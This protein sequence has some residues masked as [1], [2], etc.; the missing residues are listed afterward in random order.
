[1]FCFSLFPGRLSWLSIYFELLDVGKI[2]GKVPKSLMPRLTLTLGLSTLHCLHICK[3]D[4]SF[5]S[6]CSLADCPVCLLL[7]PSPLTL[8]G[9]LVAPARIICLKKTQSYNNLGKM[10]SFKYLNKR[11]RA[12]LKGTVDEDFNTG[13]FQILLKGLASYC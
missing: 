8:S 13:I 11:C 4:G 5:V 10:T 12:K 3:V 1:M 6:L 9:R 2:R 7:S